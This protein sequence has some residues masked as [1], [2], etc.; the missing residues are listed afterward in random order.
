[1]PGYQ[2]SNNIELE[3]DWAA[4]AVARSTSTKRKLYGKGNAGKKA[5]TSGGASGASTSRYFNNRFRGG[6]KKR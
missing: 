2:N 3:E 4:N 5:K 1:L 6:G